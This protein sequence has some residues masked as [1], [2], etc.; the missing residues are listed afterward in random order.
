MKVDNVKGDHRNKGLILEGNN[1]NLYMAQII[2][3]ELNRNVPKISKVSEYPGQ[4][5]KL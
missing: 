2:L 3:E 4:N 5:P 1:R